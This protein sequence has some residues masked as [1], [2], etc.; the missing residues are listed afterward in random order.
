MI[1]KIDC[2]YLVLGGGWSGLILAE[3][4]SRNNKRVVILEREP[5]IG[6]LA[7]TI[8]FKGFRFDLGGHRLCFNEPKNLDY[9]RGLLRSSDF[10]RIKRVSKIF[11]NRKYIDYPASLSSIFKIDKKYATR[12]LLDLF[13]R[14]KI[15][16]DDNFENWV[17]EKYG[18]CLYDIYFRDYTEKVW[19]VS[20]SELS[21]SW[22]DRR[23]GCNNLLLSPKNIFSARY[24]VKDTEK[25]FIYPKSGIGSLIGALEKRVSGCEIYKNINLGNFACSGGAI[26]SLSFSMDN[27]LFH[28]S[29][30]NLFSTIPVKEL[31]NV[32]PAVPEDISFQVK[33]GIKYR[34]LILVSFIV[35]S[36]LLTNWH[37]CY[38]PSKDLIF[39]RIHEPKFWFKAIALPDKTLICLEIF[40]TFSDRY[41]RMSER[42]LIDCAKQSLLSIGIIEKDIICDTCIKKIEYAY[43]LH[44]KGFEAPLE[45]VKDYI[46][47]FR[48]IKLV[49]RSGSHSYY[50]MEECLIDA[51]NAIPLSD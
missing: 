9:L 12:I 48:N 35:K 25:F 44:Y 43:P 37:W 18:D 11:F 32:F 15:K 21:S 28:V 19:G 36:A 3:L 42:E 40:S 46:A 22:A 13:K 5:D 1:K 49:G 31:I 39:S 6:G 23:I 34:S 4:L 7:R 24:K 41:W 26:D 47:S 8:D 33:N 50:D 14:K 30:K 27:G 29:F 16:E 51:R 17:K 2:D 38:F 45:K 10:L 20:C